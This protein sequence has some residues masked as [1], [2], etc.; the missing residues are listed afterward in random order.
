MHDK[1]IHKE[2]KKYDTVECFWPFVHNIVKVLHSEAVK[3]YR[4]FLLSIFKAAKRPYKCLIKS[5][6]KKL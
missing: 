3:V 1:H 6:F 4:N 5:C 2:D